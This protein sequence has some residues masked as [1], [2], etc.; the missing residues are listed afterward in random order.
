MPN[1]TRAWDCG[2]GLL[3]IDAG[4]DER[5]RVFYRDQVGGYW[6]VERALVDTGY[7]PIELPFGEL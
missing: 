7:R 3:S 2:T 6:P 1:R 5:I 4:I